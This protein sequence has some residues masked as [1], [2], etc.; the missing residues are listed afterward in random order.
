[1]PNYI[2]MKEASIKKISQNG[3]AVSLISYVKSGP[4][5]DP[6]LTPFEL[7]TKALQTNFNSNEIDGTVIL[8]SDVKYLFSGDVEPVIGMQIQDGSK[9]YEIKNVWSLKPGDVLILS[10]V[11]ARL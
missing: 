1:M 8:A 6:V 10:E 7:E 2:R 11:Q 4:T 9:K 5:Y 3:R